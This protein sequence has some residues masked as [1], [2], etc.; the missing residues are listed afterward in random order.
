[1]TGSWKQSLAFVADNYYLL[2]PENCTDNNPATI[3]SLDTAGNFPAVMDQFI[4]DMVPG[5]FDV[6]RF[7]QDDYG[8]RSGNPAA[9]DLLTADLIA[10]INGEN[11]Q[12]ITYS[13][14][15]AIT[16]LVR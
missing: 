12:I 7:Y 14:H 3:C 6:T 4:S 16:G 15:G 13:G 10:K 8:C 2:P 1:M 11:A 9:C 5:S